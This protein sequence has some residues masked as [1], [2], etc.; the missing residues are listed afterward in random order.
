MKTRAYPLLIHL[1]IVVF[2]VFVGACSKA[3]S[4]KLSIDNLSVTA[5]GGNY[6][7]EVKS[8]VHWQLSGI[9]DFISCTPSS[10]EGN[11]TIS[12]QVQANLKHTERTATL[13]I[14]GG[15]QL[16]STLNIT[17]QQYTLNTAPTAP[18]LLTPTAQQ[19]A[20]SVIT[21][22]SWEASTD[23]NDDEILYYLYYSLDQQSWN[24]IPCGAETTYTLKLPM[25]GESLYYWKVLA[26]D[27]RSGYT[28]S[29]VG[30]FTTD[31]SNYHNEGDVRTLM[32][33]RENNGVN[34]VFM[35]DGYTTKDLVIGG[36]YDQMAERAVE[37][38][39]DIEPYKTY[40]DNFN[41][42]LVYSYSDDSGISYGAENKLKNTSFSLTCDKDSRTSTR[43]E[44]NQNKVLTYAQMAPVGPLTETLVIVLANDTRYAGT[45]WM[46]TN[47]QAIALF[48]TPE[49]NYPYN[50]K[51]TLQH[52]AGGHGFGKLADEY[53]NAA[54]ASTRS[55]NDIP[56]QHLL[57]AYANVD[58]TQNLST[59]HWK[60]FIDLPGYES[61]GA[62]EGGYYFAAGVWRPEGS[63]CMINNIAY[64]NA[65]SREAIV[66]R[67]KKI[68]K[69]EYSFEDFLAKDVLV[70]P[71]EIP[72]PPTKGQEHLY[73]HPPIWVK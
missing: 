72:P 58:T 33:N 23:E 52:E 16:S 70:L 2:C 37:Y 55:R 60:H 41:A 6:S 68:A 20:V 1:S 36:I 67:I 61:T 44:C 63:S 57:G 31:V 64:F 12:I 10:G 39:F 45:C 13:I 27:N 62:I 21:S 32:L 22:F 5:Q 7:F 35:C 42:Y 69:E 11:T 48:T 66:K 73:L 49:D 65:P 26:N 34:L 19:E 54:T 8:N 40:R 17:Q 59:I 51:G 46:W 29:T 53:V 3:D 9:P 18:K 71:A 28:E 30:S 43:I 47:G 56:A 4:L 15:S 25:Q 50:F 24:S 38:F 14:N